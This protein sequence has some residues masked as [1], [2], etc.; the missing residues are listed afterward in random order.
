VKRLRDAFYE[1]RCCSGAEARRA[2]GGDM[3]RGLQL[4][5]AEARCAGGVMLGWQRE[6]AAAVT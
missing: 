6:E 2:V 1:L 4:R 3:T 5:G